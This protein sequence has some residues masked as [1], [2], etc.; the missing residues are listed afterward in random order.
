[1]A[2]ITGKIK[3]DQVN[4]LFFGEVL[5]LVVRDILAWYGYLHT[6]HTDIPFAY[7]MSD[8]RLIEFLEMAVLLSISMACNRHSFSGEISTMHTKQD[9]LRI[10]TTDCNIASLCS[11]SKCCCCCCCVVV[12]VVVVVGC[13]RLLF[14]VMVLVNLCDRC[15]QHMSSACS[16]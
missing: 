11:R 9:V 12:V 15:R 8:I 3:R 13:E 16:C 1:M 14:A 5:G 10:L 2:R 7:T 6:R 4:C